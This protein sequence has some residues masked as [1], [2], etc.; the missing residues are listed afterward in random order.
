MFQRLMLCLEM[1]LPDTGRAM[2][3][4]RP[5]LPSSIGM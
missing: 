1:P 4:P 3:E 5:E 2:R